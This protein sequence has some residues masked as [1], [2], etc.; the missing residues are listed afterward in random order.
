[1]TLSLSSIMITPAVRNYLAT[2]GA[3]M[4]R[5]AFFCTQGASGAEGAF[6]QMAEL[7]GKQ[8]AASLVVTE[9]ELKQP[10]YADNVRSFAEPLSKKA[11]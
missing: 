10:D 3:Q 7:C 6:A 1:M 5:V 9:G 8:P 2:C 4:K 11:F